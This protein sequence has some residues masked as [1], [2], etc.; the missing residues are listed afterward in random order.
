MSQGGNAPHR[1]RELREELAAVAAGRSVDGYPDQA[2]LT[3]AGRVGD[4]ELLG[5]HAVL[6]G[7]RGELQVYAHVQPPGLAQPYR[8]ARAR[9]PSYCYNKLADPSA[10]KPP[11]THAL[12]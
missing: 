8:P 1:V 6:Q 12:A 10:L 5:V 9:R 4:Q 3:R 2:R 7:Q 11:G